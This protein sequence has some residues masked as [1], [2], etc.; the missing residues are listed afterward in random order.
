MAIP[1]PKFWDERMRDC[2]YSDGTEHSLVEHGRPRFYFRNRNRGP[3]FRER[4]DVRM[5]E[6]WNRRAWCRH[7]L[8]RG[9]RRRASALRATRQLGC[10]DR[11]STHDRSTAE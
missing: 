1:E 4:R 7:L 6:D 10:G 3:L 2:G 8:L 11:W 9:C 5:K